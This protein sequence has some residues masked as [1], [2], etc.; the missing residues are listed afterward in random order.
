MAKGE[1]SD[2]IMKMV[3]NGNPIPAEGITELVSS[4]RSP[5]P[6]MKDFNPGY[7]FEVERFSFRAGTV[8]DEASVGKDKKKHDKKKENKGAG[9]IAKAGA[10]QSWRS[11]KVHKYPVDLQPISFS[12]MI[13]AASPALIQACID[14]SSFDSATIIKRKAAGS[15]AAGEVYLRID[16]VGVLVIEVEWEDE[17]EIKEDV[18]FI[19]RNVTI[20]YRPQ[21][22]DG[23]LGGIV[24]GFWSMV[25]NDR[26]VTLR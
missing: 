6:L 26:P 9:S 8:D 21:K 14:C 7:M 16:F 17:D 15:I 12:R 11:G 19:S 24:T 3:L 23:S 20:S 10:Y 4:E 22:P 5:N 1:H 2:I 13:D 18:K 25:P